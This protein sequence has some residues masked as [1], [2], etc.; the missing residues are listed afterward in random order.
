[1]SRKRDF[2]GKRVS[3]TNDCQ[4][5]NRSASRTG[6]DPGAL[7]LHTSQVKRPIPEHGSSEAGP[8]DAL[9]DASGLSVRLGSLEL[10]NPVM[11][12]SGCFG[13]ELAELVPVESLGAVVTKTIFMQPRGG[14]PA[15]RLA[16]VSG[17]MLNSV[18]IPSPGIDEFRRRVLPAYR[19]LGPKLVVSLGGLSVS[20][21]FDV[22]DALSDEAIDAFE[23]NLSCPNLGHG[24]LEIGST[25]AMIEQVTRGVLA[26]AEGRPV[27]VKLTPNVA[28][29]P[30][31]ARAAESAGAD[32]VTVAN[33]L[34][35]MVLQR[36]TRRP[37]LGTNTG[38]VSGPIVRPIVLRM[39]WQTA[40]AV[41]IP[42]VASGGITSVD[43]VLDYLAVGA[44][45]V[46]VGTASFARPS[47]MVEIVT[48][49]PERIREIGRRHD[50]GTAG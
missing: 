45:A 40:G 43:D 34:I 47:T 18:G 27:I 30:D 3:S 11:P 37:V 10:D 20:D 42:V 29:V 49:L 19:R 31:L 36:G 38:G 21:Y 9:D 8:R 44:T 28:S 15:H 25:P 7:Q 1:M 17:G 50:H 12:A 26:R 13:P 39:V 35:G 6:V 2:H 14:N 23:I 33:T 22:T 5:T 46:Q 48:T 24:G 41:T 32:A 16:E 4:G